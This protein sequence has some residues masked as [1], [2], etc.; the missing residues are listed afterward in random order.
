MKVWMAALI[1]LLFVPALLILYVSVEMLLDTNNE[2]DRTVM[3]VQLYVGP[4]TRSVTGLW[5]P[6]P[7]KGVAFYKRNRPGVQQFQ[8]SEKSRDAQFAEQKAG[9][10]SKQDISIEMNKK[11][12]SNSSYYTGQPGEKLVK[13]P[14]FVDSRDP[15]GPGEGG[16]AVQVN[17][18]QLSSEEKAR[19]DEGWRHNSFNQ[20]VS[21]MIS[22]H[23]SLPDAWSPEC[24]KRNFRTD[25]PET[26]VIIIFHNEAW[27]V[28]LRSVH[29][30]LSRT[31]THLLREV[32]L[33]DDFSTMD[34]LKRP[35][36]EYWKDN[37]RVKIVRAQKREGLTRARLLGYNV[38]TAPLLVFFD[39][40]IEC[41]P[42]WY[43]PLADRIT[44]NPTVIAYPSIEVIDDNTLHTIPNHN[45]DVK[46]VFRW[47][48]LSFAYAP[49]TDDER[50]ARTSP[51]DPINSPTMPGGL[52]AVDRD[53][54]TKLGTYDPG[55][56]YWGGENLELS[57]KAWMC[58]G[59]VEL[60]P[61]SHVGHI[62]RKSNPIKWMTY[63][64]VTNVARVAAVWMDKYANYFLE[65][66]VFKVGDYGDV[67]ERQRLRESLHCKSFDW[68]MK[69]ISHMKDPYVEVVHAG[70]LICKASGLCL[71][72]LAHNHGQPLLYTC[73]KL[74]G[75]QFW[76]ISRD[77]QVFQDNLKVC[78]RSQTDVIIDSNCR[79]TWNL[80]QDEQ[81]LNIPT[82]RCLEGGAT[83]GKANDQR[84]VTLQPCDPDNPR[85][86][87]KTTPRR[88]DVDFPRYS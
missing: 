71:D 10:Q 11:H 85:Q 12:P 74:G 21:D 35:L 43:E 9:V 64:G 86:K 45:V 62:F 20:Y 22:V 55:L 37:P 34:H 68:F 7:K 24:K 88:T 72:S 39:S 41:Y 13:I 77:G 76:Y 83:T 84:A 32:I 44:T 50:R 19:Y 6:M 40:H 42:G 56:A 80:T 66:N 8:K 54:F 51:S 5:K 52:F 70:E 48:D 2:F 65:R 27:S 46:G 59:S 33:V 14:F 69:N 63:L 3:N 30:V 15:D 82:N 61:C 58:N 28:L 23:R 75:N 87:W 29:S 17:V 47:G 1:C 79:D 49:L 78:S 4:S 36:D 18:S 60:I 31:P 38:A 57:F 67:S 16:E 73:H 26:S 81:L 53:F 25:L